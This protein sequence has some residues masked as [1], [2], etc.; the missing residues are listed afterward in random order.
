MRSGLQ[1]L[2]GGE[3][4][5]L[6]AVGDAELSQDALDV[7]PD[8]A[9]TDRQLRCD[10]GVGQALSQEREHSCSRR[11]RPKS[12]RS[13]SDRVPSRP[14][15]GTTTPLEGVD[16]D[17]DSSTGRPCATAN[18]ASR[19]SERPTASAWSNSASPRAR[20]TSPSSDRTGSRMATRA[21]RSAQAERRRL[22]GGGQRGTD[23][24]GPTPPRRTLPDRSP[25]TRRPRGRWRCSTFPRKLCRTSRIAALDADPGERRQC[26]RDMARRTRRPQQFQ[27][28]LGKLPRIDRSH[29]RDRRTHPNFA[30]PV[31]L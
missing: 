14:A 28:L 20:L 13:P 29:R 17:P 16:A 7:G 22:R 25:T 9:L 1:V 12:R 10:L 24:L 31:R 21:A 2:A 5:G 30:G 27:R 23:R 18:A 3:L 4:G 19:D 15:S 6:A 11:V 26:D 8:C